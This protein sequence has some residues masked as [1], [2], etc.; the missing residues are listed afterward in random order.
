M[1]FENSNNSASRSCS[2]IDQANEETKSNPSDLDKSVTS[3]SDTLSRYKEYTKK[4]R[5]KDDSLK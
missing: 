5:S 1:Q 3:Q 2:E 4:R